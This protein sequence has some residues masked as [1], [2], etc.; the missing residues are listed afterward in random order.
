VEDLG[1]SFIIVGIRERLRRIEG[2]K[3]G[4]KNISPQVIDLKF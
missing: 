2:Y 1:I 3:L 4:D